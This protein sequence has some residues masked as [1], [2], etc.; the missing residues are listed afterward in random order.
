MTH[1]HSR[2]T[3][4]LGA[5]ALAVA[6][7]AGSSAWAQPGLKVAQSK[8]GS[9]WVARIGVAS[10]QA[11]AALGAR[12]GARP[13]PVA[14]RHRAPGLRAAGFGL[15]GVD[16]E[17]EDIGPNGPDGPSS[18][19]AA[20]LGG[21]LVGLEAQDPDQIAARARQAGVRVFRDLVVAGRRVIT[22]EAGPLGAPFEIAGALAPQAPG[23]PSQVNGV[24]IACLDP[25]R[26]AALAKVIFEAPAQDAVVNL[27]G[28]PVRFVRS[29]SAVGV[30]VFALDLAGGPPLAVRA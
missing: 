17:F 21:G 29:A 14:T 15:A 16:V 9:P 24:T 13:W 26:A 20:A 11:I 2:R 19:Q 10:P 5:G 22:L 12:L 30:G 8:V 18:L 3:L 4:I 28:F 27:S 23:P 1:D 7:S 6:A 25:G